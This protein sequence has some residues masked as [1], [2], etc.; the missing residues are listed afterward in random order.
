MPRHK[1]VPEYSEELALRIA[2]RVAEGESLKHISQQRYYPNLA[3]L[4]K[5]IQRL[6]EF[7]HIMQQARQDRARTLEA[8]LQEIANEAR[9]VKDSLQLNALKLRAEILQRL[10]Q[11]ADPQRYSPQSQQ[12]IETRGSF[13]DL[14][15]KAAEKRKGRKDTASVLA[16][17][18]DEEDDQ[19][20]TSSEQAA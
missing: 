11:W 20:L 5:W 17:P 13:T 4:Y 18:E 6:P 15:D 12:V 16:W 3:T 2:K 7:A 8:D 10:A 9:Q 1:N 14:L 19:A